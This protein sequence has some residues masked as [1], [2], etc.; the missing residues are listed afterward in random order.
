M[1]AVE[2]ACFPS[3]QDERRPSLGNLVCILEF[4]LGQ[5]SGYVGTTCVGPVFWHFLNGAREEVHLMR[6][7]TWGFGVCS[8]GTPTLCPLFLPLL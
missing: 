4:S 8:V 6:L 2:G 7:G 1:A 5:L 3:A